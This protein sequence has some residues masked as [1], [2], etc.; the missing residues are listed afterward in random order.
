MLSAELERFNQAISLAQSGSK[1]AA[2]SIIVELLRSYPQDPNLL[3]WFAFTTADLTQAQLALVKV[4]VLDPANPALPEAETWLSQ[5]Q[6][7]RATAAWF[8]TATPTSQITTP[9]N[10]FNATPMLQTAG[11][12]ANFTNFQTSGARTQSPVNSTTSTDANT[13]A[14]Y[15]RTAGP[16]VRYQT[17]APSYF[18]KIVLGWQFLKQAVGMAKTNPDLIKP[19]FYAIGANFLASLLLAAPFIILY[20]SVKSDTVIYLALFGMFVVNYFITYFFSAVTIHLVHQH[21]TKAKSEIKLAWDAARRNGPA[22]L[23]VA[24]VSAFLNALRL[25]LRDRENGVWGIVGSIIARLVEAIWTTA[26]FFI[27]PAIVLENREMGD[28]VK[29]ATSIIKG[30]LLQFGIGYIGVGLV[31]NVLGLL[32]SLAGLLVA[33]GIYFALVKVSALVAIMLALVVFIAILAVVSAFKS[34]LKIAY[35]TCMFDWAR[36]SESVGSFAPAPAPLELVL[37]TYAVG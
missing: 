33:L 10:Q 24:M 31:C 11:A 3:L 6:T 12:A 18:D 8:K 9:P 15:Y 30:N 35:Y 28:A 1:Q 32:A 29:R 2:R 7:E 23:L 13:G 4:R 22:I 20:L 34:Y 17:T 25:A 26:T 27:L 36:Q 5:Q 37:R 14:G 21:L 19:S 16:G